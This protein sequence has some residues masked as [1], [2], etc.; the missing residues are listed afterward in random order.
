MFEPDSTIAELVENYDFLEK[1]GLL[2]DHALTANLL[3]HSQIMLYGSAS[4]ERFEIEGR[5]LLD[6]KLPFEAGYR[7][8]NDDVGR[9]CA[10]MRRLASAYFMGMDV[11]RKA[12]V[13]T[14]DGPEV[15]RI[16]KGAFCACLRHAGNSAGG[17]YERMEQEFL[18]GLRRAVCSNP[19]NGSSITQR[20]R[21]H[22]EIKDLKQKQDFSFG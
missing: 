8:K 21:E 13:G 12:G 15:N 10:T 14:V 18:D 9:V 22:R 1:L 2:S 6:E 3:Y 16:L 19:K 17:D 5:L 4:W 7:F 20:H 11:A